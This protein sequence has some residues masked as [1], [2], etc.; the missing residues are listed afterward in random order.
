MTPAAAPTSTPP[1]VPSSTAPLRAG[2]LPVPSDLA[3][4]QSVAPLPISEVAAAAGI[5]PDELELHG[6]SMA[7]VS[8]SVRD[9]LSARAPGRLVIVAGINPTS[10]GEGKSTT[11]VGLSQGLAQIGRTVVTCVRQPSLGPTF[12]IKGGAAGGGWSQVIPM[13]EFNLHC[14]HDVHAVSITNN[15]LAAAL[16]TRML[17][18][19]TQT[20]EALFRRMCPPKGADGARQ[21][22]PTMVRRLRK[23]GIHKT[24]PATLTPEEVSRFVRL[25]IDPATVTWNRVVDVNDRALRAIRVGLGATESARI[26]PRETRFDIAVASEVMAVLALTTDLADLRE[27][28]GSIVVGEARSGELVTADDLGVGGALTVLMKDALMPT[29]FQTLE[30]TP[31]LVHAGPFA[32]LASG[33]SS[34]VADQIGLQLVGEGGFVVTEAGFGS[35]IGLEKFVSL[36]CRSSGLRPAVAVVV[37]TVRALKMHGGGPPV[38]A[39]TPLSHVYKREDVELVRRGCG[40]LDRHV[41]HAASYGVPVVVCCNR[42][43]TDTQAELDVVLSSALRAGAF[44]AVVANHW[45]EGGK[46]AVDLARAV[47]AASDAAAGGDGFRL[48]YEDDMPLKAKIMAVAT[49]V[50]GAEGV[51]FSDKALAALD[52]YQKLGFG[53]LPVCIAKTQYSLSADAALKGAPTGFTVPVREVRL[54]AG[55]GFILVLCG[56]IETMPG[57]PTRPA[58]YDIDIDTKTGQVIGLM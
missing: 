15:L 39:G 52:K 58:Y 11:T 19:A 40:N 29:L 35:E 27:R 32:N 34:V 45:E 54:C 37:A 28:L 7:K 33:N 26:P 20:D 51:E 56:T 23:L 10:L 49:R 17:H 6:P 12:G 2:V 8:L 57:L 18:E 41:A 53:R 9:R 24:D 31:T 13:Q 48:L 44:D 47:V 3:I 46:G 14:T 4:A 22:S 25:D 43:S 1:A 55:A 16:E 42:F 50:Y 21:F 5:L 30:R 38:V 36:K